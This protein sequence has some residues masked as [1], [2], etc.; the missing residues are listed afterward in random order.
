MRRFIRY[1]YEYENGQRIRNVGFAKVEE[2]ENSTSVTIHGKGLHLK[3][4]ETLKLYIFYMDDNVCR[5][6][7]QGDIQ[8]VNPALN[9]RLIF[10]E[11]DTGR[12]ENYSQIE[13]IILEMPGHRKLAAVWNDMDVNVDEMVL[14]D[15]C[16]CGSDLGTEP[17]AEPESI[18]EPESEG[19]CLGNFN[20]VPK[21]EPEEEI[22]RYIPT[23]VPEI[24]KIDRKDI[25]RLPRCEWRLANNSFLLHGYNN[26]HHLI[27]TEDSEGFW[28][29]VPG[30]FH[31]KEAKAAEAFGFPR[32]LAIEED[33]FGAND[34]SEQFGYWCRKVRR[35]IQ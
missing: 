30:I 28:L 21:E 32:F 16:E 4:D 15:A 33:E 1:L 19:K 24:E 23:S 29:G 31:E 27:L 12:P 9:Y 35:G 8:N 2:W 13:G 20:P 25:A 7:W 3:G 17:I 18:E 14:W 34:S 10:T 22:D 6:I 11:E 26:Y 5:G